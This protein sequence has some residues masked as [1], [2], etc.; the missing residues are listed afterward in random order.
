M[1]GIPKHS[2]SEND[3]TLPD[4]TTIFIRILD[5]LDNTPI[6]FANDEKHHVNLRANPYITDHVDPNSIGAF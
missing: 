5:Q 3:R 1:P 6:E 2:A 4:P